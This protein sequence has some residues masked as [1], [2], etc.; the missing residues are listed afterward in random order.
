[1]LSVPV[2]VGVVIS[3]IAFASTLWNIVTISLRQRIIPRHLQGRVNSAYRMV[4][5]GAMPLGALLGGVLAGAW[6]LRVPFF[7]AAAL[8]V[9]STVL[10]VARINHRSIADALARAEAGA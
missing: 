10:A 6:G 7:T 8:L 4:G 3:G 1:M 2:A 9:V 5:M